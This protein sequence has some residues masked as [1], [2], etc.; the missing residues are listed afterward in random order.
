MTELMQPTGPSQV[1]YEVGLSGQQGFPVPFRFDDQSDLVVSL[2]GVV[3]GAWSLTTTAMQDGIY[4]QANV[5]LTEPAV[6]TVVEIRRATELSQGASWPNGSAFNVKALNA[7]FSRVWM[8]LQDLSRTVGNALRGPAHEAAF[9]L[10]PSA[11]DRAGSYVMFD[12]EGKVTTGAPVAGV[13]TAS[14]FGKTL[15]NSSSALVAR[16]LLGVNRYV[17]VKVDFGATGNG[18]T[19]DRAAIQA[20]VDSGATMVYVPPGAYRLVGAV[21][22]RPGQTMF[23]DDPLTTYFMPATSGQTCLQYFI[24][25]GPPLTVNGFTITGLGFFMAST[26]LAYG[27]AI[28][29]LDGTRR[30]SIVKVNNCYFANGACGTF[31][32][33]CV[34]LEINRCF[35]N[36]CATGIW[37]DTCADVDIIGGRAQNGSQYGI[38][39]DGAPGPIDEGVRVLGFSTNGQHGGIA[40]TGQDWGQITGCSFTSTMSG[41]QACYMA[42]VAAWKLV[43]SEF[44]RGDGTGTAVL[45]DGSSRECIISGCYMVL[46]D[47]GLDL[48]GSNHNVTGNIFNGNSV[49]DLKNASTASVVAANVFASQGPLNSVTVVVPA[50]HTNISANLSNAPLSI[51]GVSEQTGLNLVY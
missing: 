11:A 51:T 42:S 40:V 41:G 7:E 26:T 46:A 38:R 31:F 34:N 15:V 25:A 36:V 3:T 35:F 27:L 44:A 18:T 10:L 13:V 22:L 30:A 43:G 48:R 4:L 6:S 32:E 24:G 16:N 19:D 47:T 1:R 39:V 45:I 17:N 23:G 49:V 2:G 9:D 20:A 12:A 37:L 28:R 21:N 5:I 8:A 14:P 33:F 29:G 50:N